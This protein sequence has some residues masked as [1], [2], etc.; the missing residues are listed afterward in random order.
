MH[1]VRGHF[2]DY[3]NG[4]GLFG[5]LKGLYWWDMHVAGDI[6]NGQIVKDYSI[7]NINHAAA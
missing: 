1:I 3:R 7:G 4:G 2:K 6:S 5:K